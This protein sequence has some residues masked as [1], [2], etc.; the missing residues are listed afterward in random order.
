MK[1]RP[2]RKPPQA[3]LMT[4]MDV[5]RLLADHA[6]VEDFADLM[7]IRI[8]K[9]FGL[10]EDQELWLENIHPDLAKIV[11]N[12]ILY[13]MQVRAAKSYVGVGK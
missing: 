6:R 1:S 8:R 9:M 11:T 2:Q 3:R 12:Q 7:K 10:P 5:V 4:D 13:E